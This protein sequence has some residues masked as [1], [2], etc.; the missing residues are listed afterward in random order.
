MLTTAGY[1]ATHIIW[2]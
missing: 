1:V 2:L